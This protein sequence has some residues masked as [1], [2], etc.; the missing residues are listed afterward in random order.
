M[1]VYS[2]FFMFSVLVGALLQRE[3]IDH[4]MRTG[5]EENLNVVTVT[6]VDSP[7][8]ATSKDSINYCKI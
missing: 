4:L 3:A 5:Q 8:S 1:F 6:L 7:E 2:A